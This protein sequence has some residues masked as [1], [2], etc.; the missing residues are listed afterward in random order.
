MFQNTKTHRNF[1]RTEFWISAEWRATEPLVGNA[2]E[3][4]G[5]GF[6]TRSSWWGLR[7]RMVY[8]LW[9]HGGSWG[10]LLVNKPIFVPFHKNIRTEMMDRSLIYTAGVNVKV[11]DVLSSFSFQFWP[12]WHLEFWRLGAWVHRSGSVKE[13]FTALF[14]SNRFKPGKRWAWCGLW[15]YSACF[16]VATREAEV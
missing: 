9:W 10:G 4:R 2:Q 6:I 16:L 12:L 13:I 14:L 11:L 7:C 3:P 1:P 5:P 15:R 8:F